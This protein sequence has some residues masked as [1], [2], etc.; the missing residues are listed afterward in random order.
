MP[1]LERARRQMGAA[2]ADALRAEG[3][4]RPA[5]PG[6]AEAGWEYDYAAYQPLR[7]FSAEFEPRPR[8]HAPIVLPTIEQRQAREKL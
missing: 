7:E 2:A 8:A 3:A 6:S 5:R 1:H 4:P